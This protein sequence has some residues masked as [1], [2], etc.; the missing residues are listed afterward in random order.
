MIGQER[1]FGYGQDYDRFGRGLDGIKGVEFT[2]ISL[3]TEEGP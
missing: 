3:Q 2:R 1:P